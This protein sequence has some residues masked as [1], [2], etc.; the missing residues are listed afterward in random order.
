MAK[1]VSLDTAFVSTSLLWGRSPF[2]KHS[3][4]LLPGPLGSSSKAHQ[5][6]LSDFPEDLLFIENVGDEHPDS[7]GGH[8]LN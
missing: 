1:Q 8:V 4:V 6:V 5:G 3:S 7:S 2:N